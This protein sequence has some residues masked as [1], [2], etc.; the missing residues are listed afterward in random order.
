MSTVNVMSIGMF[1]KNAGR[2][3]FNILFMMVYPICIAFSSGNV[4]QAIVTFLVYTSIIIGL[5][6]QLWVAYVIFVFYIL[7]AIIMAVWV[8]VDMM[9]G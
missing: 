4:R 2:M 1:L 5:I 9:R 8:T 3:I 6:L 7:F